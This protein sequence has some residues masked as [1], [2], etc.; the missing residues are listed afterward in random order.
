M[1]TTYHL[2]LAG[3]PVTV[4]LIGDH[5]QAHLPALGLAVTAATFEDAHRELRSMVPTALEHL[6]Q[7]ASV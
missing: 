4:T 5:Y 2:S 6:Y 3:Y 7:M 1:S